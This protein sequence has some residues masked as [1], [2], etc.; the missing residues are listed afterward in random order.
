MVTDD[1]PAYILVPKAG[2]PRYY[3]GLYKVV[4]Y[5]PQMSKAGFKVW[6]YVLRRDEYPGKENHWFMVELY[7]GL[8]SEEEEYSDRDPMMDSRKR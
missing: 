7:K 8:S 4:K 6:R 3:S 1:S 2:S 5:W